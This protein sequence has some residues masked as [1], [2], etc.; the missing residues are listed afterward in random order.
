MGLQ[1][2]KKP[3][4]FSPI[5]II[6]ANIILLL[7]AILMTIKQDK[8]SQR[9]A[10]FGWVGFLLFLILSIGIF[11]IN[12]SV[13]YISIIGL[14]VLVIYLTWPPFNLGSAI[15]LIMGVG[16]ITIFPYFYKQFIITMEK[17]QAELDEE[18]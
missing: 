4:K 9:V 8:F 5:V 18:G 12:W 17:S 16:I 10:I 11:L 15:H 14:D 2:T 1:P 3:F 7:V 6:I 13:I